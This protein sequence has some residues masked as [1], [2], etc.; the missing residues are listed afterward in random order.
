MGTYIHGIFENPQIT[1]RWFDS[2]GLPDIKTSELEGLEAR[3]KEYDLLAE[4]FEEHIDV[5]S[6]MDMMG[7]H[8]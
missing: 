8:L 1:A 7:L 3:D 5:K 4:Y 2:I 6:I